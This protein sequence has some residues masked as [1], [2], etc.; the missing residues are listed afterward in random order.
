MGGAINIITR[1]KGRQGIHG[2][3]SLQAG[4]LAKRAYSLNENLSL[5]YTA[6]NG[7]YANGSVFNQNVQG[8]NATLP[9]PEDQSVYRT[10]DKDDFRKTDVY[11]KTGYSAGPWDVNIAFKNTDQHADIE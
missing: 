1:K 11:L 6:K 9:P 8:L 3:A 2:S 5:N 4:L 7:W 10:A